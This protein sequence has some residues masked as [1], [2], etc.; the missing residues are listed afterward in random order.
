MS[1]FNDV[2]LPVAGVVAALASRTQRRRNSTV[3]PKR[4]PNQEW[5]PASAELST[6]APFRRGDGY[7]DS[8]IGQL[9][10]VVIHGFADGRGI[11]A[12]SG[13]EVFDR[14]RRARLKD[15]VPDHR[16]QFFHVH[17]RPSIDESVH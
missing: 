12:C 1:I 3:G 5:Q 17:S 7:G 10:P 14:S 2:L 6:V 4:Y 13:R 16:A 11:L 15:V 8:I 9:E